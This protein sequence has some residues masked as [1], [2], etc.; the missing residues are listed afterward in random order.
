MV[1]NEYFL[2][3]FLLLSLLYSLNTWPI[4]TINMLFTVI[5]IQNKYHVSVL[6]SLFYIFP[7]CDECTNLQHLLHVLYSSIRIKPWYI[8]ET[9][10]WK[11]ICIVSAEYMKSAWLCHTIVFWLPR[12]YKSSSGR[13][14][15]EYAALVL[16]MEVNPSA[17]VYYHRQRWHN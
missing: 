9:F 8:F 15:A 12:G 10:H 11:V 7:N 13:I 3:Y 16:N 2:C 4:C 14:L 17:K 6:V 1:N 5:K